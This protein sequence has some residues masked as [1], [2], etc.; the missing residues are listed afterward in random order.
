MTTASSLPCSVLS[1]NE[2]VARGAWEAGARYAVGYPGTPSTEILETVA[3]R[4]PGI[5]T[6][7]ATNEK[8]ALEEGAGAAFGGLRTLVTMKHVGLNV[9]ADPLFT[10]AYTGVKAG[11]VIITADDPGMHSSQN[12]QDNRNY[13][14]FAKVPMLEPADSDEARRMTRLA[15]EISERFDTPVL[16]RLTTRLSH[17]HTIVREDEPLAPPVPGF[18]RDIKKYVMVPAHARSRRLV[19]RERSRQL[20]EYAEQCP[21]N[22]IY[23][24]R[25]GQTAR[26]GIISSGIPFQY[27]MEAAAGEADVL[28]LGLV[29][30]LPEAMIREF[31]VA[32]EILYVV[33]E[34]DPFLNQQIR[35]MGIAVTGPA[36]EERV[37]ELTP[38]IIKQELDAL[39]GA[40]KAASLQT[41]MAAPANLPPRPPVMCPGCPHRGVF[42]ALSLLKLNVTGDIGCY[43]LG[44]LSPLEAMDTCI[45]MG[46][47][48]SMQIG[49]EAAIGPG[50][51]V[52][53]IGDSTFLHSGLTPLIDLAYTKGQGTIIILDNRTTAMTGG[54]PHAGT[55]KAI[56]GEES[57]RV[58]FF[59]LCR[60][61]GIDDVRE[62]D[63]YNLD[64]TIK[65]IQD[66][67]AALHPTVLIT[68][69]PCVMNDEFKEGHNADD[70]FEIAGDECNFCQ[71]CAALGCPALSVDIGN[72]RVTISK[73]YC[74]GCH[75]CVEVCDF[76][77]IK[78]H[79]E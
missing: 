38:Q 25:E 76:G 78:K 5:N 32:H 63:P 68:S 35:A 10:A 46:A 11:L 6:H 1:G 49:M 47:S 65:T 62:L 31:A 77:A 41:P 33:E 15:F 72:E 27:A 57:P 66:A 13:A 3:A 67:V 64:T 7:W 50:K 42:Y 58:D 19:M 4:F 55:G 23:P 52:A 37:G 18:T 14:P 79:G 40:A 29:Y 26:V 30:P 16:L 71:S 56:H 17:S 69:M 36:A 54:Q 2:A 24:A 22:M 75:L 43:T 8:V 9:A 12:E 21:E 20:R 74:L 44:A 70:Y 28:K 73:E 59:Q 53:V 34:L 48:V 39:T 61:C 45:C 60:A 51:A